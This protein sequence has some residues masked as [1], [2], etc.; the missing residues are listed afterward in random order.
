M[1]EFTN[2]SFW[3]CAT[4]SLWQLATIFTKLT[5]QS[6]AEKLTRTKRWRKTREREEKREQRLSCMRFDLTGKHKVKEIAS[7]TMKIPKYCSFRLFLDAGKTVSKNLSIFMLLN[8]KTIDGH[9]WMA[10]VR[11]K[12][13]RC[14]CNQ[15]SA[16]L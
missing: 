16:L 7:V 3:L 9:K 2:D 4:I 10:C 8:N 12:K 6:T 14:W 5:T 1:T 13:D 11:L 15:E